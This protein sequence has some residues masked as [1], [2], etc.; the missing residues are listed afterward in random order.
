MLAY[1]AI[2]TIIIAMVDNLQNPIEIIKSWPDQEPL[3]PEELIIVNAATRGFWKIQ[4]GRNRPISQNVS[5]FTRSV[6]PEEMRVEGFREYPGSSQRFIDGRREIGQRLVD[7]ELLSWGFGVYVGDV[8]ARTR[9]YEITYAAH[10]M[11]GDG[12]LDLAINDKPRAIDAKVM[13]G[14]SKAIDRANPSLG[15]TVVAQVVHLAY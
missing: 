8:A 1:P 10:N 15:P 5:N 9:P 3:G 2:S 4:T 11:W 7:D 14:V 12:S 13:V 6:W